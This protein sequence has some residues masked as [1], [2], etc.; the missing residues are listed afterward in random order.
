MFLGCVVLQ[1]YCGYSYISAVCSVCALRSVAVL[2]ISLMY[3]P[4]TLFI[5]FLIDFDMLPVVIIFIIILVITCMQGIYNY[6]PETNHV[7]SV[8]S[9]AAVLYWQS[10]LHIMLFRTWNIFCSFVLALS[11]V[12]VIVIIIIIIIITTT[13]TIIIVVVVSKCFSPLE[14]CTRKIKMEDQ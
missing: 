8:Y 10:V 5:Y 3:F 11:V 7:S 6:L 1:A 14:R 2:T 4:G 9:V 12:C 13:T